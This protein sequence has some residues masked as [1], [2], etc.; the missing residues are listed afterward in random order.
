MHYPVDEVNRRPY[1]LVD[2]KKVFTDGKD[3]LVKSNETKS[4]DAPHEGFVKRR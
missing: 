4:A 1:K 3:Q 2:G